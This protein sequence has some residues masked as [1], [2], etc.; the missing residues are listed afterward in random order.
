[1]TDRYF[2]RWWLKPNPE[3]LSCDPALLCTQIMHVA[4]P[5]NDTLMHAHRGRRPPG[6]GLLQSRFFS[7][8]CG[9]FAR[10]SLERGHI[11][12]G[13]SKQ[14]W[15]VDV[16]AWDA[17]LGSPP[18][19][20]TALP[21]KQLRL[22]YFPFFFFFSFLVKPCSVPEKTESLFVFNACSIPQVILT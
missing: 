18:L 10:P 20:I 1:M 8:H 5:I 9:P 7:L 4:S 15:H 2:S 12:Q 11:L 14:R 17:A 22:F 21:E 3:W 6:A 13:V 16:L 19:Y